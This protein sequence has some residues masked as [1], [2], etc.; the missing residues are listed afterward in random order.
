MHLIVDG[1]GGNYQRLA[2]LDYIFDLLD[3]YPDRIGMTKIMPPYVFK[4]RGKRPEDW[5]VSGF[6]IIAESHISMHTF[7][8]K[9]YINIDV[10]SC[11]EFETELVIQHMK[12]AFGAERVECRILERGLEYPFDTI[13]AADLINRE[14]RELWTPE[15]PGLVFEAEKVAAAR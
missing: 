6:V 8:E 11:K 12:E 4:Y 5:G 3:N 10:F 13:A 9:G 14:R 15:Q 7:P 2:D 1:F